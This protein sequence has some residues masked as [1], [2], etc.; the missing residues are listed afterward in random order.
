MA[1]ICRAPGSALPGWQGAGSGPAART[2]GRLN[3]VIAA[4]TRMHSPADTAKECPD[5][6]R[7]SEDAED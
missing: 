6:D 3:S 2:A 7:N 1:L 4:D 5:L